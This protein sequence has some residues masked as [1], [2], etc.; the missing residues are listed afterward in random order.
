LKEQFQTRFR[1]FKCAEDRIRIFENPF[2]A[3]KIETLPTKF[4]LEV[5]ELISNN[6]FKDYFKEASLQQF[7]AM[8]PKESF[9]NLK[10]HAREMMSIFSSKYLC[11]QT[12]SKMKYVKSKYRTNL[13]DEHLQATLL[14]GTTKFDANY[15]DILKN[16]QFQTSH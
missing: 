3:L 5:I 1:D 15:Q 11:E 7:Y 10:K 8:L 9:P 4:Q 2:V 12:F 6:N 16:K 14:I 13:S